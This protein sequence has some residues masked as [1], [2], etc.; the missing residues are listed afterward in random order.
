MTLLSGPLG[1]DAVQ[2][3]QACLIANCSHSLV[4][5][6]AMLSAVSYITSIVQTMLWLYGRPGVCCNG[7][8]ASFNTLTAHDKLHMFCMG[9]L[10]LHVLMLIFAA[11]DR[12]MEKEQEMEDKR[13]GTAQ[14][15]SLIST[16]SMDLAN[17]ESSATFLKTRYSIKAAFGSVRLNSTI[18]VCTT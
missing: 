6:C 12:L 5:R 10:E 8:T 1:H 15:Q 9:L 2:L 4:C 17:A 3:L 11:L 18:C 7:V 16:L 13:R 14:Q